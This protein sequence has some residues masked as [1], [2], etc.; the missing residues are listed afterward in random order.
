[1]A[2]ALGEVEIAAFADYHVNGN[3]VTAKLLPNMEDSTSIAYSAWDSILALGR[4]NV[5]QMEDVCA[6]IEVV[7]PAP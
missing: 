3:S 1:M 7:Q 6:Q 4:G 2:C 5:N